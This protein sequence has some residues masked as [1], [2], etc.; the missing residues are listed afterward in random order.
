MR[1]FTS[2][3]ISITL[4]VNAYS[5]TVVD[6]GVTSSGL[7][8]WFSRSLRPPVDLG[9]SAGITTQITHEKTIYETGIL[10][11]YQKA[12]SKCTEPSPIVNICAKSIR[13]KIY[14]LGIPISFSPRIFYSWEVRPYLGMLFE[15]MVSGFP[16]GTIDQYRSFNPYLT[17][18][19]KYSFIDKSKFKANA[20]FK[21]EASLLDVERN[22]P[23]D[24]NKRIGIGIQFYFL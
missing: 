14:C 15:Y 20:M 8:T 17:I 11:Y 7:M 5:Q 1:L 18:N 23:Y 3:L 12:L 10:L 19:W 9:Y 21:M 4:S 2:L 6:V 13:E 24:I 16:V 22:K